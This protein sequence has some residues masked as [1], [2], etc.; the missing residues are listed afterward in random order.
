MEHKL[1]QLDEFQEKQDEELKLPN[2]FEKDQNQTRFTGEVF[3]ESNA[4]IQQ[5]SNR[6][7]HPNDFHEDHSMIVFDEQASL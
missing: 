6:D 2:I 5:R 7:K 4:E 1:I 3:E